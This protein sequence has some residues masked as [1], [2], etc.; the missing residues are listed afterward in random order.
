MGITFEM[1]SY[2]LK[3][4]QKD[5]RVTFIMQRTKRIL[6]RETFAK[7]KFQEIAELSSHVNP[8]CLYNAR[9]AEYNRLLNLPLR[10]V[11]DENRYW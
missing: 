6:S 10:T 7:Q 5:A 9:K 1:E 4:D 8:V 2:L 11:E 3:A